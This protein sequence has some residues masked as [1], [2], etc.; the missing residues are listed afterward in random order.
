LGSAKCI[1]AR[2]RAEFD[3]AGAFVLV[4]EERSRPKR[5][6]AMSMILSQSGGWEHKAMLL[7]ACAALAFTSVVGGSATSEREKTVLVLGDSLAAGYGLDPSEAFPALL[8]AKADARGWKYKIINAGLSGDTS[9]GGL[10]RIDWLL[11][12]RIDVLLLELGG[13]DG[14]R[15]IPSQT[16]RANL[17]AIIDRVRQR[18]PE[19]IVCVIGMRMPPNMGSEYVQAFQ[20]IFPDLAKANHAAL[21]P[22]LLEGV[23]GRP[24]LNQ[25]D[26]IHPTAEGQAIVA[27]NVWQVL[28]PILRPSA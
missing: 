22:F 6:A 16:T 8:Q 7:L 12:Q 18:Y 20:N 19:V 25:A 4:D 1:L 9:A 14:L 23:G 2:L 21:V 15:G 24:E 10:R 27:E 3:T 17:Q 13:N 26:R 11:K 5:F 28:E